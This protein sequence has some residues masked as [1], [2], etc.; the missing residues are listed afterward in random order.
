MVLENEE[1]TSMND[2]DGIS[3]YKKAFRELHGFEPT[4]LHKGSWIYICV[5]K[6]SK[7]NGPYRKHQLSEFAAR[8]RRWK[9]HGPSFE[10]P[11]NDPPPSS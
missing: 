6:G 10:L 11:D 3:E 8:L 7:P 1:G 5:R 4:F 9:D 2:N